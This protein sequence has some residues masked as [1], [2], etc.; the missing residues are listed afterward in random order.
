MED[1]IAST[2][3]CLDFVSDLK[4][5]KSM[6]KI[7]VKV[8]RLWKQ[9]TCVLGETMEMVLADSKGDMIHATVKKELVSQFVTLI[10][11]GE[12]KLM[13]NFIVTMAA[14]SY[15]PTKHPYRIVFLPTTRLRMCD[16]LPSNL[17]GL[18]PVK[19]ES[20][21]DGSQNTDYLVD[22]IGQ[23][24]EVS[25][26]EV[27]SVNGKDTQKLSL[28][29]RN[30]D[31]DRLPMVLWGKF[32]TD[33]N[34]AIQLRGEHKIIVVLRFGKI[35][36]WKDERSISNAYNVSDVALNPNL[37]E[38]QAFIELL[39]KDDMA[40]AIVDP[41]PLA[42][43]NGV[44]DKDD[45]FI[46]TPRKSIADVKASRQVEKCVVMCTIA[47]I[48]SD[49][50]WFYLSCKV[51]SK[52]VLTVP[53]ESEDDGLDLFKHNYFCVK[54]NQHD[55]RLIPRYKL[56]VVVLDH[57]SDTKFLLFDNL[58]LQLLHQPCI[59]LTGPITDEEVQE[60]YL[61]PAAINNLVGK[62]FLFKIQIE[63]EN[64]LYKHETYKV[65][66]IIT[67][68]DMI[69]QF[70]LT[71]SPTGSETFK[72]IDNS[73]VSD[74]PEGSMMLRGCSSQQSDSTSLTPA[75]RIGAPVINLDETFD[76]TSV[77]RTNCPVK[78]KKEKKDKS[79]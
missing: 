45:F 2:I 52:K 31:D 29:L 6:W 73:I 7:R 41:K 9:Y 16:A 35:K 69:S 11:Q 34:D 71:Q 63:R 26:V 54:C 15:R 3:S 74:A 50:G 60:P 4:P 72:A 13:V 33:V 10:S 20:I 75:K 64:Y 56:H 79:G 28:E 23:I 42:L 55:P 12:S 78:I 58:A 51:C 17:T 49:M 14:G 62:T 5:F 59:E 19:F 8:I 46:H 68:T 61:L 25:H 21:K 27:V 22:V 47:G 37:E 53:S 67:N 36:V 24:V 66:K 40:L 39:P 1:G 65:L 38:V 18:D 70:D 32:A 43:T 44:S 76:Q 30:Q 77:T 57:T 48:D